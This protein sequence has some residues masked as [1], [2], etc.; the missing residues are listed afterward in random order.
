[1]TEH[2][3]I[4]KGTAF[5]SKSAT[6]VQIL[7]DYLFFINADGMIDKTVA[8]EH[9]DYQQLLTTY[10]HQNNFY[11]LSEGQYFLPGFVDLHVQRRNG[12]NQVQL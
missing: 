11:Q 5:T 2:T 8:P 3:H 9:T 4:F 10:Q 1:M 12:P 6:E 7:K